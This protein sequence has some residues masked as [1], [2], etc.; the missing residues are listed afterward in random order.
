MALLGTV[1]A[2]DNLDASNIFEQNNLDFST[3]GIHTSPYDGINE[4]LYGHAVLIT[5]RDEYVQNYSQLQTGVLFNRFDDIYV[6]SN[7]NTNDSTDWKVVGQA[8]AM[9]LRFE[10][11]DASY[12]LISYSDTIGEFTGDVKNN[13]V[14]PVYRFDGPASDTLYPELLVE[15]QSR[16]CLL[17][18]SDA[19]D[20]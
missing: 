18:T 8:R 19:A 6:D 20:E 15:R 12:N 14:W 16:N 5:V 11:Y 3:S 17:Y 13:N 1:G 10:F 2:N 4:D 9:G 7:G